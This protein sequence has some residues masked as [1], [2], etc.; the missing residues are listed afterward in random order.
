MSKLVVP[1]D[2]RIHIVDYAGV[3]PQY[4]TTK[5]TRCKVTRD[6]TERGIGS[7]EPP[8]LAAQVSALSEASIDASAV[9]REIV[10]IVIATNE[11]HEYDA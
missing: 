5:Q 11:N 8:T 6:P 1:D 10:S 2:L 7:D 3:L 4:M 9:M